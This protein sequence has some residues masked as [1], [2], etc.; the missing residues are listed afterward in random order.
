M[1]SRVTLV[2]LL[3][4]VGLS[5]AAVEAAPPVLTAIT[6]RGAERRKTIEIV[7]TGANLSPQ[8]RLVIPFKAAQKLLPEA[9]PNAA[10]ARFQLTVDPTVPLGIYP[11]RVATEDGVSGLLFFTVDT[12][13]SVAEQENNDTFDKAQKVP[14]PVIV[15]GQCAGGG[16]DFFRFTVKK[17]QRV[18]AET[19]AARL[20][21]GVMPQIRVTDSAERFIAS[22]DS[23]KVRGDCR[24]IFTAPEDGDYVV[25]ISDSR[26]R[27]GNPPFYRLKIADYDVIDEVF[28]LGGR[29]G[30]TVSFT[31]RGGTLARPVVVK[32]TLSGPAISG[33]IPLVLD[34]AVKPGMLFPLV[35]VGDLPER[36]RVQAGNRDP[37]GQDVVPPVTINGRLTRPGDLDRFQFPVQSGQR[38]RFTVRA[39]ALGSRLDG[40]L[41]VAD[42]A[43]NQLALVDDVSLPVA[44]GQP[45]RLNVDPAIDVTVPASATMLVVELRDQRQRGGVNFGYRLTIEPIV[46]DFIV[47]QPVAEVNVPRGGTVA[48]TVPVTRRGF[49][50]PISLTIPGLPAGWAAQGGYV[51]EGGSFGVLTLTA[52]L[53]APAEILFFSIAGKSASAG[54]E[55]VRAGE[56]QILLGSDPSTTTRMMTLKQFAVGLTAAEPFAVKAPATLE[57][58]KGYPAAVPVT[59]TRGAG[60]ASLAVEVTGSASTA[61]PQAGQPAAPAG[62]LTFKPGVAPANGT[63]AAFTITA[64]LTAPEGRTVDLLVQGKA[65]VNNV[66]RVVIGPPVAL[67]V[68]RPFVVELLTPSLTFAPGGTAVLKARVKRHALFKEPVQAALTGLPKGVALTAPPKPLT[69]T[70]TELQIELRVDPKATIAAGNLNLTCTATIA[71]TAYAHPAVAVAVKAAGK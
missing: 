21:S 19:E 53:T 60:Q 68:V 13:P 67:T 52:P 71:G 55:V 36:T 11:V 40:V 22:D 57:I 47:H 39:D 69:S 12:F 18:V 33:S 62:T 4:L 8:S 51:P 1:K 7:L 37:K 41:R 5:S 20:G 70:Q 9:K 48:L 27:G 45:A 32:Q 3:A 15:D 61:R 66:D 2:A 49:T 28:P 16:V 38:F 46:P 10:R 54:Q 23:Q 44:A 24:V 30:E 34:G 6:P 65:K 42:Q 50:G 26:Y 63:S 43:G 29:R 59:V 58:V 35:A 14:F 56:Q 25:E 64:G 17:G 31:L